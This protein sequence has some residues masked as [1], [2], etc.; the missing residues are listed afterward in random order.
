MT[1]PRLSDGVV[2]LRAH[3]EDDVDTCLEQST[4][5]VSV[6]WTQVPV[7]YTREDAKRFIR[8][9]MPGGW[10]SG[11][12]FGFAVE[13]AGDAGNPRYAGTV[14]LRDRG[15]GRAEIAY[16]AHPWARGRGIVDR[17]LRLL[18]A[19]GFDDPAG[20]RLSTVIWWAEVGNWASRK[21]AWRL[22]FSCE[23]AV[24]HWL[25]GRSGLVD[26]WIGALDRDSE[27][28][29]R[30]PWREAPRIHGDGVV[31]R[32]HREEDLGRIVEACSEE[33]TAY[34]LAEIPAPYGE[35][36]ARRF[37]L[38]RAEEMAAGGAVVWAV[39]DPDADLLL[40][41][42]S[43]HGLDS[44]AGPEIGFWTH[45]AARGHGIMT[46]AVRLAVRHAFIDVGDGGLGLE[47][48]R[49]AAA[50]DNAASRRVALANGFREIGIERAGTRCRDGRHDAALYDLLPRDARAGAGAVTARPGRR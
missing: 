16:G 17:A 5:P 14:S 39:A 44:A 50:V 15:P 46:E 31:L 24:P 22:G 21:T 25:D 8:Q 20:P 12:E 42:L 13:A 7:P 26:A 3:R 49:L 45:P 38:R 29:P 19:W 23:G 48:L 18:L 4:D 11:Q 41:T 33:R 30:H 35:A 40:G 27:R 32:A 47:K 37:L 28:L 34:W 1:V 9:A 10:A 6:R 43:L 2:T 36:E